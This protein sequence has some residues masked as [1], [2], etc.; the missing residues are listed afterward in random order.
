MKR[1]TKYYLNLLTIIVGV[2]LSSYLFLSC[3]TKNNSSVEASITINKD[4]NAEAYNPMIFGG[5]LEHFGKPNHTNK[6]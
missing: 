6:Y 5:F 1:Y 3:T 4:E 2:S